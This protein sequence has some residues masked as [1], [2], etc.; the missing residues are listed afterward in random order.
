MAV[1]YE[2]DEGK[3]VMLFARPEADPPTLHLPLDVSGWHEIR[4]GVYYG[5]APDRALQMKLSG[6]PAYSRMRK[7]SYRSEKD[8]HY[9]DKALG[10]FD[11][12]E[13]FWKCADLTGQDLLIAHP[14]RGD[15][16]DLESNLAY[17]RLVPMGSEEI[18][19][20]Q[21]ERPTPH[22][23]RL[24]ATYDGGN[25][26][27]WGPVSHEDFLAEFEHLR[28][29]DFD[30]VSY[31]M[32]RGSNTFYP[33]KVGTMTPP[34]GNFGIG[35]HVNEAVKAGVDP[36]AE[37]I[38][39]ANQCGLRLFPHNRL[40]GSQLPTRH[41]P[42]E[43]GGPFLREHPE[44]MATYADGEPTRHL[45]FAYPGV[46]EFHVQLLREW[47]EDYKADGISLLFSR[48]FPF[49]YYEQPVC[50]AFQAKY[51]EAMRGLPV[52]DVRMQR[53]RA[54]FLTQ[55][56]REVRE[57]LDDV[58]RAQGRHIPS[59]YI[60]PSRNAPAN[61]TPEV[62]QSAL[63][64]CLFSAL[65]VEAWVREDLV[66]YLVMHLHVY[67]LHDGTKMQPRIRELA[68]LTQGTRT[69]L[70][71]DIYPRRMPPRQYRLIAQSYYAAGADGLA[72]WD[73]YNRYFRISEWAFVKRLGHREDLDRW[74]HGNMHYFRVVPLHRLD[75]FAT[76]REFSMPSDG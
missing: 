13:A 41:L 29:S 42:A 46:R 55:F 24:I 36:L 6:D 56:L 70:H 8:G 31:C 28:D 53:I 22:T 1:D 5:G 66:D 68:Q 38:K 64:E 61:R 69:K 34:T 7:E 27:Q 3:G 19:R 73:A 26:K 49:V 16:S 33:S 45:S 60:V 50:D 39:A 10:P 43:Y 54:S 12:A 25:L 57:M 75:G 65:H 32:A 37:A 76:G 47:V 67:G 4:L 35:R 58:G 74:P 52:G 59:C 9:P 15:M 17:V 44:W 40:M 48:S 62:E 63:A 23:K 21:A 30:L 20:A 18:A 11:L 14:P 71:V 72:F 51:G 2:T